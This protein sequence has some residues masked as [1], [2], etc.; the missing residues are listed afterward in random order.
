MWC[1]QT[2]LRPYHKDIYT[3][4]A[5]PGWISFQRWSGG[6]M[7]GWG[8]HGLDQVQ[9]A[10]GTSDTGPVEIWTEG[11]SFAPPTFDRPAG[12]TDAE[13]L[14]SQPTVFMRYADG[15]LLTLGNGPP[16]GAIFIGDKGRITIGRGTCH[17]EPEPLA[18]ALGAIEE[19]GRESHMAN[20]FACLRSRERPVADVEIGQRSTTLCHLGNIARWA[21]R[22]LRWNPERETFIDDTQANQ[23]LSRAQ[24]KGYQLPT[25]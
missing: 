11:P 13:R 21:G 5:R 14:C 19:S 1:G 18:Q 25:L 20:W 7:T 3:P 12:R 4:R 23:W 15:T 22:R 6:E 17:V 24:R 8:A 2:E 9:L 16:G 10:L